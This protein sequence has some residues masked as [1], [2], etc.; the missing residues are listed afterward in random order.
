MLTW[1]PAGLASQHASALYQTILYKELQPL[2]DPYRIA[3]PVSD[4]P[5]LNQSATS[6]APRRRLM[7]QR[8]PNN[9]QCTRQQC[10]ETRRC[11][12]GAAEPAAYRLLRPFSCGG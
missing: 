1:I 7:L 2:Q 3:V 10:C 11:N 4:K 8:L 9:V 6:T 5:A 12:N